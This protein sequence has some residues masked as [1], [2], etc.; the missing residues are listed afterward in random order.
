MTDPRGLPGLFRK[1]N[2]HPRGVVHVGAHLGQEVPSYRRCGFERIVLVEP[3]PVLAAQLR[4]MPGVEVIEAAC[5]SSAGR[6]ILHVTERDKLSSL[7]RPLTRTVVDTIE[8]EVCR[9]ADLI[10]SSINVAVIDVQGS[11]LEV[12]AGAPLDRLDLVMLET[13]TRSKYA[14]APGHD[15]AVLS[16]GSIG[17]RVAGVYP[18]GPKG[19]CRDVAFVPRGRGGVADD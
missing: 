18:H 17:W 11:E 2:I 13:H 6:R 10:D 9:L 5:A 19:K 4:G 1:H 15:E 16:M 3:N 14:G 8:V 12:V 7:Y